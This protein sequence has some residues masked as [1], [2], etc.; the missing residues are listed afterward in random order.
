MEGREGEQGRMEGW[1][2]GMEG[3]GGEQ[4]RMGAKEVR[5]GE[6]VRMGA[7]ECI[8]HIIHHNIMNNTTN[9]Y[10]ENIKQKS[11]SMDMVNDEP[12]K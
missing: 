9:D 8:L 10:T 2:G 6:Q 12:K 1:R 7:K 3:R 5:E 11:Y 4:G